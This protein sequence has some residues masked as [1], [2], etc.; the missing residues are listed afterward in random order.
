MPLISAVRSA[1]HRLGLV[2][3][4]GVERARP[5]SHLILKSGES[6]KSHRSLGNREKDYKDNCE[7]AGGKGPVRMCAMI[8]RRFPEGSARRQLQPEATGAIMEVTKWL[9][10]SDVGSRIG[11]RASANAL[12]C[13]DESRA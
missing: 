11:D 12:P 3:L 10:P 1:L 8:R 4:A 6:I 5:R 13:S 2:P 7:N 9:K